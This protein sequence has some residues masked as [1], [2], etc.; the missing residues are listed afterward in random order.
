VAALLLAAAAVGWVQADR[1]MG[2]A[3]PQVETPSTDAARGHQPT[4]TI[5]RRH[6]GTRF[7][8]G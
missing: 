8:S 1:I 2:I 7:C 3:S 5:K 4:I 6:S